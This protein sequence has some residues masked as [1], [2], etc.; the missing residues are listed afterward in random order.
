MNES[1]IRAFLSR[2]LVGEADDKDSLRRFREFFAE[3]DLYPENGRVRFLLG[4]HAPYSCMPSLLK[5]ITEYG[6]EKG[7]MATVHLSE[8]ETEVKNMAEGHNKITPIQYVAE[9]G[10]FELPTIAAHC[11]N[12][13]AED[14]DILKKHDV[15]IVINPKSNMK[16]GNGFA[17]V[18]QFLEK[19]I[20]VCIGTDGSGSNNTQNLFRE[21]NTAALIYKGKEKKAKCVDAADVLKFATVNAAKALGMEEQ[22]GVLKEG[23]LADVILL[24]LNQPQFVPQNNI[25]SGLV[26]SADGSEVETVIIDGQIVM[27]KRKIKTIDVEEVYRKCEEIASR[28]GM[29]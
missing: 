7:L 15:S 27:E 3:I 28:L 11:V 6:K 12:V 1:G 29:N 5:K 14:L 4:P 26:Y 13:T 20:N 16:L 19:K 2:G 23:A 8:S 18:P 17:P 24:D 21:M 10:L 22:L 9:S 25:I